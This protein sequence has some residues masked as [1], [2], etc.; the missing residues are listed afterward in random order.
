MKKYFIHLGIWCCLLVNSLRCQNPTN[1]NLSSPES[2]TTDTYIRAQ[3]E[4]QL[5]HGFSYSALSS[6]DPLLNLSISTL[7]SNIGTFYGSITGS[8][9]SNPV[10]PQGSIQTSSGCAGHSSTSGYQVGETEGGFAVGATGGATYQIPVYVAP[11]TAGMEPK[12]SVVYNNQS[13]T[14][15]LGKGFDISGLSSITRTTKNLYN[16]VA[17]GGVN[18][19]LNDV[20]ALDGNRLYLLTGTYGVDASTYYS[21]NE[22]FATIKAN[23]SAGNGPQWI[24]VVDKNGNTLEYGNTSD[25]R[26]TGVSG[27]GTIYSWKLNKITDQF[28]NY[29]TYTYNQLPGECV[30]KTIAYTGNTNASQSPYNSINFSYLPIGEKNTYYIGGVAFHKT[31]LLSEI[32]VLA[33]GQQ[34]KKY[35]FDYL[36][37]NASLLGRVT[38][39]DADGNVTVY[40]ARLVAKGF[41]QIQ[42]V[43]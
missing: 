43:D 17:M 2:I 30:I 26:L 42:G 18:L 1:I 38:E 21:E 37:G 14:G 31:Q 27:D 22:A 11:G 28:G 3:N 13:S 34:A 36:W 12:I 29:V 33:E 5:L 25:S 41:R 7:P 32:A 20:Y 9:G 15:L 24:K 8:G 40:K 23:G 16:D 10:A 19:D 4:I 6:S 39:T 35:S